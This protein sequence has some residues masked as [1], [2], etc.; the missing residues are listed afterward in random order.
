MPLAAI[1][2]DRLIASRPCLW[3]RRSYA[4]MDWRRALIYRVTLVDYVAGDAIMTRQLA[5]LRLLCCALY[6]ILTRGSGQDDASSRR[7]AMM[8]AIMTRPPT[9]ACRGH[10][11]HARQ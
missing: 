9:L 3:R 2:A 10:M 8:G 11:P 1:D 7:C 5:E 4:P 6:F